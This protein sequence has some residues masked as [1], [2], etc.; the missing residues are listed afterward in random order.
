MALV[1]RGDLLRE[2][3]SWSSNGYLRLKI[4]SPIEAAVCNNWHVI[5]YVVSQID[6]IKTLH[7]MAMYIAFC[8]TPDIM[9]RFLDTYSHRILPDYT[10]LLESAM[11]GNLDDH[12]DNTLMVK[13]ILQ[14]GKLTIS[15]TRECF[16]YTYHVWLG[17]VEV[18]VIEMRFDMFVDPYGTNDTTVIISRIMNTFQFTQLRQMWRT[19]RLDYY[20]LTWA[21]IIGNECLLGHWLDVKIRRHR[22]YEVY[23][24]FDPWSEKLI[25]F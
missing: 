3:L 19:N 8:G 18:G 11:H 14:R 6:N 15:R 25:N 17:K 24:R 1:F 20:G 21:Q 22:K 10:R 13:L 7:N 9:N 2:I 23:S 5:E 16:A 12:R 4:F